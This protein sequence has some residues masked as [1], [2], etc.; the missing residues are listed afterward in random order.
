MGGCL[1]PPRQDATNSNH[2]TTSNQLPLPSHSD[3]LLPTCP[4][5]NTNLHHEEDASVTGIQTL[6][7]PPPPSSSSGLFTERRDS[8]S[9]EMN[10]RDA[11]RLST[12]QKVE[13]NHMEGIRTAAGG[14]S[15]VEEN[16]SSSP[17]AEPQPCVSRLSLFSGMELVTKTRLLC[18]REPSHTQTNNLDQFQSNRGETS[19]ESPLVSDSVAS[20][21]SQPVSAF[22]FLNF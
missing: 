20:D 14:E 5:V 17:P 19:E 18:E 1:H 13:Q 16:R 10:D 22:T 4:A 15:E 7:P 6:H 2:Q 8:S 12:G 11:E 21:G 3:P 9:A